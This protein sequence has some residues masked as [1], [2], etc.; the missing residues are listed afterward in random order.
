MRLAALVLTL[1]LAPTLGNGTAKAFDCA[2]VT[3]PSSIVICSDPELMR[4]ADERQEAIN[5]ARER[6]GEEAWSEL[7]ENH[8]AWVRSYAL[9]CGI[10]QDRPP[11]MPVPKSILGCFK[12]AAEARI[13]FIRGYGLAAPDTLRPLAR[14]IGPGFDCGKA[15]R[16][17]ALMICADPEL[18]LVDLRY[19]QAYWALLHQIDPSARQGLRQEEEAFI[20]AVQDQCA[21]PRS[22]G[23]STQVWQARDCIRGA[24]EGQ[25]NRWLS[26]LT[27]PAYEE[28]TR[29]A[30]RHLA[31]QQDLATLGFLSA[32][33]VIDGAYAAETRNAIIA[34]Q[35]ERG[36]ATT[37]SLGETDALAVEREATRGTARAPAPLP[38]V[39]GPRDQIPLTPSGNV[40]RVPVRVN[41]AITLSFVLDS[42][43]ADV[44]I[45]ADVKMTLERAGT[46]SE[47]D[48]IGTQIYTL[49]D[50]SQL[51]CDQYRLREVQLG[52]HVAHNVVASIGPVKG[53]LLLGQTFLSRFGIW[54]I[55]NTRRLLILQSTDGDQLAAS[56]PEPAVV[57]IIPAPSPT[58]DYDAFTCW[59]LKVARNEIFARHGYVFKSHELSDYFSRR[60]WYR[61][62]I[63]EVSAISLSP[64]ELR[65]TDILRAAEAKKSCGQ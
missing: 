42:G 32:A 13:A 21:I 7:W 11:P 31:L 20:G 6:I 38:M 16:P 35:T 56:A 45:P 39:P 30:E 51:R 23:L 54:A 24:Y 22:G 49:A 50:G 17:L 44:Q 36:R 46:I 61:P 33:A 59:E 28:A 19:N 4:L 65:V 15:I 63:T 18:S 41:G 5:E 14:R 60:A 43:A 47:D 9:A 58:P 29:P 53:D 52:N 48:F 27:G 3:L 12:H 57:P 62:V 1:T 55:D 2:D 25:R 40:F 37:G 8:K 26:R 64:V 10:P 34:W